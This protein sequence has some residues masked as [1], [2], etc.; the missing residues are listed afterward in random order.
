MFPNS[1]PM[2]RDA[3]SPE[4]MVFS[5][6]YI[7]P[8]LRNPP[9]KTGKTYGHRP[10]SPTRTEGLRTMVYLLVPQ[11]D[12]LRHCYHYSSVMQRALRYLLPWLWWTSAP[13]ASVYG[14]NPHQGTTFTHVTASHVTQ[15]K[16]EYEST[17]P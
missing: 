5:L 9:T 14:R 10:R 8:Q 3:P 12:R 17:Q 11:G 16:V 2:D 1:V 4:P 7:R 6:I 15:G 13:L